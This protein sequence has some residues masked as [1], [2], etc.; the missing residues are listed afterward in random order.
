VKMGSSRPDHRSA[1]STTPSS[2]S[3]SASTSTP[4]RLTTPFTASQ[5]EHYHRQDHHRRRRGSHYHSAEKT[6]MLAAHAP[7]PPPPP[8]LRSHTEVMPAPSGMLPNG[9]LDN[10]HTPRFTSGAYGNHSDIPRAHMVHPT[11]ATP[12]T[13]YNPLPLHPP[14]RPLPLIAPDLAHLPETPQLPLL[15]LP[16]HP[17]FP[18]PPGHIAD[19]KYGSMPSL[20]MP[21]RPS[22]SRAPDRSN[23]AIAAPAATR[24][25]GSSGCPYMLT[26]PA[27]HGDSLPPSSSR[28]QSSQSQPGHG[29][30]SQQP[31]E[32]P[33]SILTREKKQKACAGCRR[34]KLKC[35]TEEGQ[36]ECIRCRARSEKCYFYPRNHVSKLVDA[37]VCV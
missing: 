20:Q 6:S 22:Q 24:R 19:P 4:A 21:R 8:L 18:P 1:P 37:T 13:P 16:P 29:Q 10:G 28:R 14:A 3:A 11:L 17:Q 7:V 12:H 25:T 35:I 9:L 2:S 15:L 27:L 23:D 26:D 5:R 30:Q 34:A 31:V 32:S 33:P 36:T